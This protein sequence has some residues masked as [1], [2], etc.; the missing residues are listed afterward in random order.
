MGRTLRGGLGASGVRHPAPIMRAIRGLLHTAGMAWLEYSTR[1]VQ[2]GVWR[3]T[4]ARLRSRVLR[5][6]NSLEQANRVVRMRWVDRKVR[7]PR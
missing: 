6:W 7:Q 3:S 2:D 5:S 1:T 4:S